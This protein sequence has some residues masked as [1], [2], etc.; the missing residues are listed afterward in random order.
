M[1]LLARM[2][3]FMFD[4]AKRVNTIESYERYLKDYTEGPNLDQARRLLDPLLFEKAQKDDWY[5]SYEDYIKKCPNG[6]NVQ[7]AKERITWLKANKAVFGVDYPKALEQP[8]G[9]WSFDMKFKETG[10]KI[11]Y[12]VTGYGYIYDAKGGRWGT[13]GGRIGRG[14]KEVPAGGTATDSYWCSGSGNHTFCNGYAWF[15]WSGEDAGGHPV[16]MEVKVQF[17]HPGCT[18]KSN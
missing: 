9:R 1:S 7:K 16:K 15:S 13:Y 18:G 8:G 3:P 12:K 5:S 2:E 17:K 14:T 6:T 10:G 4:W 11:G